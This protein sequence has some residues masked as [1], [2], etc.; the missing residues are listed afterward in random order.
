[1]TIEEAEESVGRGVVY[2]PYPQAVPEDGEIVRVSGEY[3][4]VRYG[5]K[6]LAT[7]PR[8]LEWLRPESPSDQPKKDAS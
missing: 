2:R 4:M 5:S 8:D 3:V 1:M 7:Y 6:V